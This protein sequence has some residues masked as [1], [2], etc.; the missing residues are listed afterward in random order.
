MVGEIAVSVVLL[1]SAG[2]LLKSFGNVLR[3]NPGFDPRNVLTVKV[4]F[5]PKKT[6]KP[7]KRLQ[8]VREL[9]ERLRALPGVESASIVNR[10]PLTGDSEIHDVKALGKPTP[11]V[12]ENIS[13]EYRVIDAAY[14]RTMQIPMIARA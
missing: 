4:S 8:H 3:E 14:F 11:K 13:A 12:P 6:D 2:L 10:L 9:L 5:D 1:V 7:E